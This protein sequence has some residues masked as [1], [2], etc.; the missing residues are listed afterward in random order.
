PIAHAIWDP[1]IG[2]P[3][4]EAFTR[5][6]AAGPVKITYSGGVGYIYNPNGNQAFRGSKTRNLVSIIICQDLSG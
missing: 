1:H 2:Q 3:A 5:G 6:G 4:V